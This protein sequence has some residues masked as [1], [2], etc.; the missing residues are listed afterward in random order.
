MK[1]NMMKRVGK[2]MKGRKAQIT[3][4]MIVGIILLFSSALIFYIKNQ[5]TEGIPA[6]FA[7]SVQEVPLEAQPI[8]LYVE[9]CLNRIAV[10]A[11]RHAGGH[12]GYIDPTDQSYGS[13]FLTGPFPTESK[14]LLVFEGTQAIVPYWWHMESSNKCLNGCQFQS[15]R[16][17]LYKAS[18]GGSIEAQ[19][20]KYISRNLD[21]C[22]QNFDPFRT[23][24]FDIAVNGEPMPEV[25][26]TEQDV[27]VLMTYPVSVG[28]EGRTTEVN[29]YFTKVN[30]NIKKVYSL[31]TEIMNT[32]VDRQFLE[33]H[34][35]NLIAFYSKP[36]GVDRLP[37]MNHMEIGGGAQYMLW[38]RTETQERLESFVLPPG[39]SMLQIFDSHNYIRHIILNDEGEDRVATGYMDK[40]LI[41]LKE[42]TP[43]PELDVRFTYLDWW[44]T[45]LSINGGQEVIKPQK[46]GPLIS[47]FM[48]DM[49]GLDRY[50][51]QY[52]LS[53]PVLVTINDPTALNGEGFSFTFALEANIRRNKPINSSYEG[54]IPY[55]A[56][57]LL[58]DH[59]QR[60]AGPI[61]IE[62]INAVNGTPVEGARVEF[63]SGDEACVIGMS[64][65]NLETGKAGMIEKFPV[66][67]GEL[68]IVKDGYVP[69]REPMAAFLR[70]EANYTIEMM[71]IFNVTATVQPL[72]LKWQ[73][74]RWQMGSNPIVS[75][76]P[77]TDNVMFTLE[78]IPDDGYGEFETFVS[79]NATS[80]PQEMLIVPGKYE[81]TGYLMQT[82]KDMVYIPKETKTINIPFKKPK[83]ITL[84]ETRMDNWIGG[85]VVLN[86]ATGYWEVTKEDLTLNSR[87]R[88]KV[89]RYEP[90]VTHSSEF[91]T[92][93]TLDQ[94]TEHEK[95]SDIYRT[96]L[97]P[98][99]S[100]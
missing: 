57:S 45:W 73:D 75:L 95:A 30:I 77:T 40:T 100:Q 50:R 54:V 36:I 5:V 42:K 17:Y 19:V 23:Q 4:F 69:V 89:L 66:G 31:A 86:N 52:S 10:D 87:V 64:E 41:E 9:N 29:Q 26:V 65:L 82:K 98:E 81:V 97:E 8:K 27:G 85:G 16:P 62:L 24:G 3:V 56:A 35:L 68:K 79:I 46:I 49:I 78:R 96:R 84:N 74:A 39:I 67:I 28:K 93:P 13:V 43:Y 99:W 6:E 53:F 83:K 63:I 55:P 14:A 25:K 33:H 1:R 90:P 12:G 80:G 11:L 18:G 51:S 60:N 2:I 38:T 94:A 59:K 70:E 22:L 44:P 7:P 21:R 34:T 20:E 72:Q 88:F 58:C 91:G 15:E 92:G 61:G 71:P 76:S 47:G 37:P 48:F 32:E